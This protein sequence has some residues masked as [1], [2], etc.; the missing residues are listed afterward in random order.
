MTALLRLVAIAAVFAGCA[1]AN[2]AS[3]DALLVWLSKPDGCMQCTACDAPSLSETV[4]ALA[5]RG[6]PVAR[7]VEHHVPVCAAC[8]ICSSGRVYAVR[9]D[10][11]HIDALMR[12]G[13]SPMREPPVGS[14]ERRE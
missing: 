13:W 2:A 10:R 12:G 14:E 7:A 8:V 9:V 1:T 6:I 11:A 4:A 3:D 5:A